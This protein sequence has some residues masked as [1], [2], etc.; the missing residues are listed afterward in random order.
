[1]TDA[2]QTPPPP[3]EPFSPDEIT[4]FG[5]P[6][7]ADIVVSTGADE[8]A[9]VSASA[10]DAGG[11]LVLAAVYGYAFEG[12]CY[13][14]ARPRTMA[15]RP[16]NQSAAD[17]CGF[18]A[19]FTMWRLDRRSG[20]VTLRVGGDALQDALIEAHSDDDRSPATYA[21]K[22]MMAHRGQHG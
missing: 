17:G 14:F 9:T 21:S 7:G 8:S 10:R 3:S 15:F 4:L 22:Y 16:R 13:R 1:M 11:D 5:T 20:V 2:T 18:G 6:V 12:A 19:G